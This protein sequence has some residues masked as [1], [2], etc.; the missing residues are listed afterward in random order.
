MEKYIENIAKKII[1]VAEEE[2]K[3]L[4]A[5]AKSGANAKIGIFHMPE[6][7]FVYEC[8]KQIMQNS[9]EIFGD[10]I[11]EWCREL[12]LGNGGLT[13]LVFAF[14]DG[15]K[16]A[17]EFKMINDKYEY[18][19]DLDKL[20]KLDKNTVKIFCALVDINK[21]EL[22]GDNIT[23]GRITYIEEGNKSYSITPIRKK[24]FETKNSR[25]NMF[26][27]VGIWIL[28]TFEE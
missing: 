19:R 5:I 24:L 2:N 1:E 8:G 22:D 27:Y 26:G 10:N 11:P 17:I 6:L 13:D 7:A 23:D 15:Q 9:N 28:E 20:S 12:G 18:R 3:Q 25:A 16:I 21:K 14:N 4:M